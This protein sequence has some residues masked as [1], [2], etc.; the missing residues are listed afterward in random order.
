MA[1]PGEEDHHHGQMD[2][3]AHDAVDSDGSHAR[4]GL[5]TTFLQVT[6]VQCHATDVGGGDAID[7]RRGGLSQHRRPEGEPLR[8]RAHDRDSTGHVGC[9][10]QGDDQRQPC[11]VRRQD[12]LPAA[13]HLCQLGK[14]EVERARRDG[15]GKQ[16]PRADALDAGQFRFLAAPGRRSGRRPCPRQQAVM[17]GDGAARAR[18]KCQRLQQRNGGRQIVRGD[19]CGCTRDGTVSTGDGAQRG[20]QLGGVKVH[21]ALRR[22]QLGKAEVGEPW[23]A[24]AVDHDVGR[25]QRTVR[26]LRLVQRI[27]LF[28]QRPEQRVGEKLRPGP[29]E[30]AAFHAF[31]CQQS[32]AIGGLDHLANSGHGHAGPLGHQ[33]DER[34]VLD[35]LNERG[36]RPGITDIPEPEQPVGA[37]QQVG[38]AIIRAKDL[39]E[40]LRAVR[41]DRDE[42]P[43]A[44]RFHSGLLHVADPQARRAKRRRDRFRPDAPVGH[45]EQDEHARPHRYPGSERQDHFRG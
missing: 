31:H 42:R 19:D 30:R 24:R 32:G 10:R 12:A 18:R 9:R 11:P 37:V 2:G 22:G 6:R 45:A 34:L 16:R 14:Q 33:C 43:R 17:V 29:A 41:G 1:R 39:D 36:S 28:P 8:H 4:A 21:L 20:Q 35:G 7:E 27:N 23:P 5:N 3:E 25:P 13:A 40:Q 38:V 44:L 15:D 26:D